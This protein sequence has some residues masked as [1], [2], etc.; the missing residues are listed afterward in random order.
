[1]RQKRRV[2]HKPKEEGGKG[3]SPQRKGTY[4]GLDVGNSAI[5]VAKVKVSENPTI[6]GWGY[7]PLDANIINNGIVENEEQ[8]AKAVQT[9]FSRAQ[10]RGKKVRTLLTGQNLVVRKLSFPPMSR[11]EIANALELQIEEHLPFSKDNVAL[12]FHTVNEADD[13]VD[14][15]VFAAPRQPI[16]DFVG[17]LE[18]AGYKVTAVDVESYVMR[19]VA[20]ACLDFYEGEKAMFIFLDIG[21]GTTN[22]S[23][24]LDDLLVMH[25][26]V[27]LAGNDFTKA[28]VKEENLDF[29]TAEMRKREVGLES[30]SSP[31]VGVRNR[32]FEEVW[33][34]IQ[35]VISSHKGYHLRQVF[36]SGG[37]SLLPNML[38]HLGR[39]MSIQL[40]AATLT[41][42]FTISRIDPLEELLPHPAD[43]EAYGIGGTVFT[44][45]VGLA[46]GG[47]GRQ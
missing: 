1:M 13:Q 36:V 30:L 31:L 38:E 28:L 35:Y 15:L 6:L 26:V 12:D 24:F 22:I 23:V 47:W 20:S 34:S 42:E 2:K 8:L 29:E 7:V 39:Y 27:G 17:V 11:K 9:A 5:K 14:I 32:L 40:D 25:R 41:N 37:G 4:I 18:R 21:A 43:L 45:A 16:I 3:I 19:R 10:I 46:L 44:A 33:R